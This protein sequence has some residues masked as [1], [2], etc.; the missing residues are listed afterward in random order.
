MHMGGRGRGRS[1]Q[2][3]RLVPEPVV[4]ICGISLTAEADH[5]DVN[6]KGRQN[7][8]GILCVFFIHN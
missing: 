6:L 5:E 3:L 8:L 1:C 2:K 7:P 4:N